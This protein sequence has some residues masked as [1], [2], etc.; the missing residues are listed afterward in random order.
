M[1]AGDT[2]RTTHRTESTD[3][4][5]SMTTATSSGTTPAVPARPAQRR[6]GT[7]GYWL[8]GIVAVLAVCGALV[9][10]TSAFLGWQNHI[11]EFPRIGSDGTVTVS[12]PDPGVRFVY[13]EHER[14]AAVPPVPA[15]TVTGPSGAEVPTAAYRAELRYDVPGEPNRVG[16]AV[17][18]FQADEPGGYL[19]SVTGIDAVTSVAVGDDL[20]RGFAPQVVLSIG[21]LLGGLLAGLVL[22]IVT[23]ARRAAWTS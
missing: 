14:S 2:H 23:A 1:T 3:M 18:T 10:G 13:V 21:L 17:L 12:V 20:A 9:W 11:R 22:V 16:D 8:G 15:V 7:A 19:V 5:T 6:P 4:S